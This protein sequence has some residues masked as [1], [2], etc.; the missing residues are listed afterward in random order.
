MEMD[1]ILLSMV[2]KAT[3]LTIPMV[4]QGIGV[5]QCPR[6]PVTRVAEKSY[7][8]WMMRTPVRLGGMGL[9]SVA[10]TSLA[11]FVGGVEQAVP[12][13]DGEGGLCTQLAPILG[14]MSQ[15][16]DRL[17]NGRGVSNSVAISKTGSFTI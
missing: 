14:D 5:E 16:A 1:R 3:G 9:R 17:Q 15:S 4:D 2:Q 7:Q 13:F 11:A 10:E 12:H 8:N 6:P